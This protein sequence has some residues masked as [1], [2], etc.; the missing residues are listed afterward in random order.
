MNLT[1]KPPM[2]LKLARPTKSPKHLERVKMLPCIICHAPPP[3]DA[4]HCIHDRFGTRKASDFE[5]IPLCKRHHQ[6]GPDAIHNGKQTWRD[7]YGADHEY[8]PVVADM[9]AGEWNK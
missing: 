5:A 4:H 1:Q 9:L 2:G 3:S 6:I 8:L 7:K